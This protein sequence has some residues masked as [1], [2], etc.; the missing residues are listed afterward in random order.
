[1]F[2]LEVSKYFFMP[3]LK[4]EA[5]KSL[6]DKNNLRMTCSQ[7]YGQ[8]ESCHSP[9]GNRDEYV[10]YL[11]EKL[12]RVT[13]AF[14]ELNC[15][16]DRLA[17]LEGS[18][19]SVTPDKLRDVS[20][21][22]PAGNSCDKPDIVILKNRLMLLE[23]KV[24]RSI[25]DSCNSLEPYQKLISRMTSL[26]ETSLRLADDA[27]GA[28]Q[29]M[30][31]ELASIKSTLVSDID[32]KLAPSEKRLSANISDS[33]DQVSQ[34]LRKL[35]AFQKILYDRTGATRANTPVI[36]PKSAAIQELY[37]EIEYMQKGKLS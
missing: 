4:S 12:E 5:C 24:N 15:L 29:S 6:K 14:L 28:V 20:L 17:R 35:I 16:E 32:A 1:M 9:D 30:N 11:E 22:A 7:D 34:V 33:I 3:S 10:A 18:R 36:D 31:A 13:N 25:R 23:E 8:S 27:M 19:D 26:E 21:C 37:R 2:A